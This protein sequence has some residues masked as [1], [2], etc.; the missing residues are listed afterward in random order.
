MSDAEIIEW[1]EEVSAPELELRDAVD[2]SDGTG[3]VYVSAVGLSIA[4]LG[5]LV[6]PVACLTGNPRPMFEV[7]V[8]GGNDFD[9][10]DC[11]ICKPAPADFHVPQAA[12]Q[13]LDMSRTSRCS[14]HSEPV[15]AEMF[16]LNASLHPEG[17]G[18][19]M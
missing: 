13:C 5:R 17:G 12:C 3:L 6:T 9:R 16:P 10:C 15:A 1:L 4:N 18:S 2:Y 8:E 19:T 11:Y 14:L 7:L